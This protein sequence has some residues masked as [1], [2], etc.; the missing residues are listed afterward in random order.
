MTKHTVTAGL[1]LA[2]GLAIASPGQAEITTI[3]IG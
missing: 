1:A 2:T 3:T